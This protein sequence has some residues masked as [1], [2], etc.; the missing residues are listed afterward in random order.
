[1]NSHTSGRFVKELDNNV[2][3]IADSEMSEEDTSL[4]CRFLSS[5]QAHDGIRAIYLVRHSE[6]HTTPNKNSKKSAKKASKEISHST[7]ILNADNFRLMKAIIECISKCRALESLTISFVKVPM[8]LL[9]SLGHAIYSNPSP[10]FRELS[11]QNSSLEDEG[12]RLLTP[13][14]AKCR[15]QIIYFDHCG[16]TDVSC[17][18]IASI[19]KAHEASMDTLYWNSTLRIDASIDDAFSAPDSYGLQAISL[20]YNKITSNGITC[21]AKF[22]KNNQWLLAI[23]F[24]CNHID[25]E[26]VVHLAKALESNT[27][28]HTIVLAGN[29][30]YND[31][32]G[33]TLDGT[34]SVA[35]SKWKYGG[36]FEKS[37][38][39]VGE[40]RPSVAAH[41]VKWLN[42]SIQK[43]LDAAEMKMKSIGFHRGSKAGKKVMRKNKVM[44]KAWAG[45]ESIATVSMT[46]S[47][48]VIEKKLDVIDPQESLDLGSIGSKSLK[49]QS[50]L[51][52][53]GEDSRDNESNTSDEDAKEEVW[54]ARIASSNFHNVEVDEMLKLL[55]EQDQNRFPLAL[56]DEQLLH[57][58][59]IAC[60]RMGPNEDV[61]SSLN[62]HLS[63]AEDPREIRDDDII[64][65]TF[66]SSNGVQS[67]SRVSYRDGPS[68]GKEKV[69]PPMRSI[70]PATLPSTLNS[71]THLD[72]LS[73]SQNA[74]AFAF[75]NDVLGDTK[76]VEAVALM[77]PIS[78]SSKGLSRTITMSAP[79]RKSASIV[80]NRQSTD[81][82]LGRRLNGPSL[83]FLEK[84]KA[85]ASLLSLKTKKSGKSKGLSTSSDSVR[86]SGAYNP[87]RSLSSTASTTV[88]NPYKY[89]T[90][91]TKPSTSG[92]STRI[93][94]SSVDARFRQNYSTVRG[95]IENSTSV[96]LNPTTRM[97]MRSHV[98]KIG[99][100]SQFGKSR[101]V[102]VASRPVGT[103]S[104]S[105]RVNTSNAGIS[106]NLVR[107]S[108][109]RVTNNRLAK[110]LAMSGVK[111]PEQLKGV[112]ATPTTSPASGNVSISNSGSSKKKQQSP[113]EQ[114]L[115]SIE[116]GV[117]QKINCAVDEVTASLHAVSRQLV[118]ANDAFT[119][120]AGSVLAHRQVQA[121]LSDE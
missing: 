77:H 19:V 49:G 59:E 28:L 116:E 78:R 103:R 18:Y 9:G 74:P 39:A 14:L 16:L 32:I 86:G 117:V 104:N 40:V 25:V 8:D 64:L 23:N 93:S 110:E 113:I 67:Q 12:L 63:L 108:T 58:G 45:E 69:A 68:L 48:H 31:K 5:K 75:T 105:K 21:L 92:T 80:H 35:H 2:L 30:G 112:P 57:E 106:T 52:D 33:Q 94:F 61:I 55:F 121:N 41:L 101:I 27:T 60:S 11:F 100:D 42:C 6:V 79:R 111:S 66:T 62:P 51:I 83:S 98:P 7:S 91:L 65:R 4:L 22:L 53:I 120:D 85:A 114:I 1:M 46:K 109:P 3:Y 13:Y 84:A 54:R 102:T 81:P 10:V 38:Y 73:D 29:P 88:I 71:P 26:G 47:V 36:K 20:R 34:A 44:K 97:R 15:N 99:Q 17:E 76:I 24:A 115:S 72:E 96:S 43:D 56:G 118:L 70:S 89:K 87:H 50:K 82:T 37:S 119:R 95:N 107:K 90:A